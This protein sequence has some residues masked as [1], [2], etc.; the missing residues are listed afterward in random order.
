MT[1]AKLDQDAVI[2]FNL[3]PHELLD[4]S[5]EDKLSWAEKITEHP[6]Q[7]NWAA[8]G[9]RWF[10]EIWSSLK[11]K[12][13][14]TGVVHYSDRNYQNLQSSVDAWELLS[15]DDPV[16]GWC[17]IISRI[18]DKQINVWVG[19]HRGSEYDPATFKSV[20]QIIR[21]AAKRLNRRLEHF[22]WWAA[23]G[24]SP[25]GPSHGKY[26]ILASSSS[27][28]PLR[29]YPAEP[30]FEEPI[31][32]DEILHKGF[33]RSWLIQVEGEAEGF[34]WNHT[35]QSVFRDLH[36]LCG[37]ASI[38]WSHPWTLRIMPKHP[39]PNPPA[40]PD[41]RLI[42]PVP[43]PRLSVEPNKMLHTPN[44]FNTA[45]NLLNQYPALD[46]ALHSYFEGLNL[47]RKHPSF[48]MIAFVG[49]IEAIGQIIPNMGKVERCE[50]CGVIKGSTQR[51]NKTL[52]LVLEDYELEEAKKS[53]YALKKGTY[54]L[55]S[56]TVHTGKMHGLEPFFGNSYSG[57]TSQ[58]DGFTYFHYIHLSRIQ[59][60]AEKLLRLIFTEALKLD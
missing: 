44:W 37:L 10:W 30:M 34:S 28:G 1:K 50:A 35:K 17:L 49:C 13:H 54:G 55:R 33:F 7:L 42:G 18:T 26:P 39:N 51:F 57:Y 11:E 41:K 5:G 60:A 45:W 52:G 36:R 43:K 22:S 47:R 58:I 46:S 48:A 8:D 25:I 14:C 4:I 15:P 53:T 38:A 12:H 21:G 16:D 24:P 3:L 31:A 2:A 29:L 20:V 6:I 59:G 19:S 56:S 32:S 40:C 23:I 27:V 9:E